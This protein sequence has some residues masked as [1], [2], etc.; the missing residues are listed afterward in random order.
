MKKY[1]FVRKYGTKNTAKKICQ[2]IVVSLSVIINHFGKSNP[3]KGKICG[4][5]SKIKKVFKCFLCI[6]ET[7]RP[8]IINENIIIHNNNVYLLSFFILNIIDGFLVDS[9][10][11]AIA[12]FPLS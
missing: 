8:L 3:K 2:L 1:D 10:K 7:S 5:F 12:V 6:H 11:T 9:S 4:F